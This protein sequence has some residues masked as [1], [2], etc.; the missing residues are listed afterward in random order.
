MLLLLARAAG[1]ATLTVGPSGT[2]ATINEAEAAAVSGDTIEIATG[3]YFEVLDPG[4]RDLV[5]S[6]PDGAT[7][8][9]TDPCL[10]VSGS[11]RVE[12]DG[13]TF[14][15]C[16]HAIS[17]TGSS[18]VVV[19]DA[20][21][22]NNAC[23]DGCGVSARQNSTVDIAGSVFTGN[24]A[25][26][27]GGSLSFDDNASLTLTT[28][29]FSAGSA[30]YGGELAFTGSGSLAVTDTTFEGARASVAGGAVWV[31]SATLATLDGVSITGA[32][33]AQGGGLWVAR[34]ELVLLDLALD[35]DTASAEGG[36]AYVEGAGHYG[37][38][39]TG[40]RITSNVAGGAGGGLYAYDVEPVT[41]TDV[42][43]EADEATYGG[44]AFLH[45]NTGSAGPTRLDGCR[46]VD[47][48]ATV[49]G[50]GLYSESN[51]SL[52]IASSAFLAGTAADQGGGLYTSDTEVWLGGDV[53]LENV[54]ADVGGGAAV[55]STVLTVENVTWACNVADRFGAGLLARVDTSDLAASVATANTPG[56][57]WIQANTSFT[58]VDDLAWG[59]GTSDWAGVS[60]PTGTDGNVSVSPGV[61]FL[62]CDGDATNDDLA[63]DAGSPLVDAATT[64]GL[65]SDGSAGDIGAYGGTWGA[66]LDVDDDG[67][68]FW[69]GDCHD[70]RADAFPGG[71]E[72]W[73]DGVD[74]DCDGNDSDQDLDGYALAD[75][76]DDVDP[77]VNPGVAETWYDGTDQDC[78]GNDADQDLDGYALADDCDDT[79]PTVNPAQV[80]VWYDGIDQDCDG[81]DQ[82]QDRDGYDLAD[83]CDDLDP[84]VNPGA[85]ETWY[86]GVDQDCDGN[87]LDQDSDGFSVFLDCDDTVATVFPGAEETWYDGVDQDCDGNDADRD[88]DS[89]SG[90]PGGDDC[91]DTD[92]A[93]NPSAEEI[94]YDGVDQDCDGRDDDQDGDGEGIDVDCDDL[95]P[96]ISPAATETWYDGIDEDCAEDDDFDQDHDG[97][98]LVDDAGDDCDD[99]DPTVHPGAR[100]LW[101]DGVDQDCDGADDDQDGDGYDRAD[102]CDDTD[103]DVNPLAEERWYDGID[104][105]CDGRDDDQDGD[106][107]NAVDD[108]DDTDPDVVRCLSRI[109]GGCNTGGGSPAWLLA[110]AAAVLVAARRGA[111]LLFLSG[112]A[113]ALDATGNDRVI[114]QPDGLLRVRGMAARDAGAVDL[115]LSGGFAGTTAE[116]VYD[117]GSTA[118][119]MA[120]LATIQ[121]GAG[122]T[123]LPGLRAEVG[124]PVVLGARVPVALGPGLGDATLALQWGALRTDA[125]ALGPAVEL[126]LPTGSAARLTGGGG[127][128]GALLAAASGDVGRLGWALEVG[129]GVRAGGSY[130]TLA[131]AP[132]P[133]LRF[134]G[135][136]R[137]KVVGPLSLGGE[138]DGHVGLGADNAVTL[139]TSGAEGL[140]HAGVDLPWIELR[141]G[142]GGGLLDGAGT[143]DGRVLVEVRSRVMDG[144]P[145]AA[146][147]D[148]DGLADAADHCPA[149]AEDRDGFEDTDGCPD[150]DDDADGVPDTADRCPADPE[151]HDGNADADG[152]PDSDDDADGLADGL[153][154]C[155]RDPGPPETN[156]CPDRDRDGMLDGADRCPDDGAVPGTDLSHSDGCPARVV[157]FPD[158]L[159][160]GESVVFEPGRPTLRPEGSAVLRDVA[161]VL[162]AWPDLLVVEIGVH[163]DDAGDAAA[164]LKLTQARAEAVK[165]ALV[166]AGIAPERLVAQGYGESS[167]VAPNDSEA[168]RE[169]NRRVEFVIVRR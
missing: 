65:D 27:S 164:N 104:Q 105:D 59:N 23:D 20:V 96:T 84:A 137:V 24:A 22:S 122:W 69:A 36:G 78:D 95:D 40:G 161:K 94:W 110:V 117:D 93:V 82:D 123:F 56:G 75:D 21:F 150:P 83:D 151:D 139:A 155:P 8:S 19:R 133:E 77:L 73:Y 113:W 108:C 162:A 50:G 37:L 106:G 68:T 132:E 47:D 100:E 114:T 147:A 157:V 1:A 90:A 98:A 153:D 103:P 85:A 55:Y 42:T 7:L 41:L 138:V 154:R 152:C 130:E 134:G 12:V 143:A 45:G 11:E 28:S 141:A 86:D 10:G 61:R 128:G 158:R 88:G 4:G 129:G 126:S 35:A 15:A 99:T 136:A 80:E 13:L 33:A 160:L 92:P 32:A 3:V 25:T 121:L 9:A 168:D 51:D 66:V 101:Y 49:D 71:T 166:A 54:G 146:D 62:T 97:W 107:T 53:F 14:D 30:A 149:V 145:R 165:K 91:D 52:E 140:V 2:Y 124:L 112:S 148:H 167:P 118:P 81:D 125:I 76:C 6:A 58:P 159:H 163:V 46:F 60:D 16:S 26:G 67:W 44:G 48:V 74:Q 169:K 39:L 5:Y 135:G 70:G 109:D 72:V 34:T 131:F 116:A 102:D 120:G 17:A 127:V 119:L 144:H 38:T 18:T 63:P 89:A 111:P 43:F 115:A 31:Q 64:T 29:T 156:G 57:F 142:G 79:D 87:D